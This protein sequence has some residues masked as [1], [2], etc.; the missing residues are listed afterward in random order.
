[1]NLTEVVGRIACGDVVVNEWQRQN[2]DGRRAQSHDEF[3]RTQHH[4]RIQTT[5]H[6]FRAVDMAGVRFGV[7]KLFVGIG[8]GGDDVR[9]HGVGR[10]REKYFRGRHQ[11]HSQ[12]Q[13]DGAASDPTRS[14]AGPA[15]VGHH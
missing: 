9:H 15:V 11:K 3:R 5:F 10:D 8:R 4:Q 12:T 1:M 14:V 2:D 13:E 7:A 6:G